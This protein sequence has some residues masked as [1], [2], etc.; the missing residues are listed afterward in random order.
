MESVS[1][2]DMRKLDKVRVHDNM[3]VRQRHGSR[4]WIIDLKYPRMGDLSLSIRV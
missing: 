4:S 2:D 1:V 3:M